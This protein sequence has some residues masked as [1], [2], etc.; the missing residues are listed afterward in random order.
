MRKFKSA[1]VYLLANITNSLMPLLLLPVFTKYLTPEEYGQV[2]L[3]QLVFIGLKSLVGQPIV[4]AGERSFFDDKI[5]SQQYINN[6]VILIL[7][8]SSFVILLSYAISDYFSELLSISKEYFYLA[9]ITSIGAVFLQLRLGQYQVRKKSIEYAFF[10]IIFSLSIN[11]LSLILVVLFLK[12]AD[13]RVYSFSIL[14]FLVIFISFYSLNKDKAIDIK[15]VKYKS[16]YVTHIIS[17]A[18]PLIPHL[19]GVFILTIFDRIILSRTIGLDSLGIYMVAFQLMSS[20]GLFSDA[21]NKF[22][23][24]YQMEMLKES[25]SSSYRNI[26]LIVYGW[27]VVLAFA[28]IISVWIFSFIV[29]EF[30]DSRYFVVMD[31]LPWLALG[32]FFNGIYLILLNNIYYNSAT[33]H[34]SYTTILIGFFHVIMM[35]FFTSNYGLNG[36]GIAFSLSMLIRVIVIFYLANRQ[37]YLPWNI[38]KKYYRE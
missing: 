21:I 1:I 26:V 7:G 3:F 32:Q 17:F 33:K 27:M 38:I 6:C 19:I 34:L 11:T 14:Y 23:Y 13:G 29:T 37:T 2:A 20:I 8:C 12:G 30:L 35:Y 24:P 16:E 4:T 10:Q 22:I 25:S 15:K 31:I 28:S 18:L 5:D 9:V 36:A